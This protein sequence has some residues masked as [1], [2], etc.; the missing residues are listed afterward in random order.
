MQTI[1]ESLRFMNR[2][3]LIRTDWSVCEAGMHKVAEMLEG[4]KMTI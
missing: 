2:Q 4:H 3:Q 1:K